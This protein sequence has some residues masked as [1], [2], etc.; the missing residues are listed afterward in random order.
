MVAGNKSD[1]SAEAHED[2]DIDVGRQRSSDVGRAISKP[3]IPQTPSLATFDALQNAEEVLRLAQ[4]TRPDKFDGAK[5]WG[6]ISNAFYR[7]EVRSDLA[8]VPTK[9]DIDAVVDLRKAAQMMVAATAKI[10]DRHRTAGA[11]V[12]TELANLL[13]QETPHMASHADTFLWQCPAAAMALED[14]AVAASKELERQRKAGASWPLLPHEPAE[15]WLVAVALP[16]V[17]TRFLGIEQTF[18]EDTATTQ[19]SAC[20]R[21]IQAAFIVMKRD[22]P[23]DAKIA[24]TVQRAKVAANRALDAARTPPRKT[25]SV[26]K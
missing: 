11:A 21:F 7:S 16:D 18:T 14:A 24:K 6:A 26:S 15:A 25:S 22:P 12:I 19:R 17:A 13:R 8:A 20:I 2:K 5:M 3:P 23:T 4:L 1:A 9:A 10:F